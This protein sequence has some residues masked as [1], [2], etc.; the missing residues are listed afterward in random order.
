[1][2]KEP[3]IDGRIANEVFSADWVHFSK[4]DITAKRGKQK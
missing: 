1:M 2:E 3:L 4:S